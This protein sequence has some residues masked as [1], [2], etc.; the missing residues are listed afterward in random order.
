MVEKALLVAKDLYPGYSLC[1]FFDNAT[2]HSDYAKNTLQIKDINKRLTGKQPILLNGWFD[3][4]SVQI[5]SFM[6]FLN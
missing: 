3:Q 1:F 6:T 4:E 2:S 5:T